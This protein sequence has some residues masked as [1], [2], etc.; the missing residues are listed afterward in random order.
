MTATNPLGVSIDLL[1]KPHRA[2]SV[3][4]AIRQEQK[5]LIPAEASEVALGMAIGH[6]SHQ[7]VMRHGR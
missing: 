6:R 2:K 7:R 3:L 4:R 1:E 5:Y